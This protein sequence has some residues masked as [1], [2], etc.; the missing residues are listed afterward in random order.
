MHHIM[1]DSLENRRESRDAS[2]KLHLSVSVFYM[3]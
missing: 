3:Y 2:E 1:M